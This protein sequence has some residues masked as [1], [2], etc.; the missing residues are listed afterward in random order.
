MN[1]LLIERKYKREKGKLRYLGLPSN[2]MNDV[3]LWIDY[4][5]NISAVERG[6]PTEEYNYQH[7]LMLTAM[8]H[9]IDDKVLIYRG[10]MDQIL[11]DGH[12]VFGN[13][14]QYPF[15]IVSL[16]YSGGII[17]KDEFGKA[18]RL[19][20]IQRMIWEQSEK[21]H[22]FLLFIST[23]LNYDD[24]G[25]IR[26]IIEEIDKHLLKLGT[27]AKKCISSY[28]NHKLEEARLKIYI[29]YLIGNLAG[30]WYQCK[31][32]KPIFY[33]GNKQTRMMN[34]STYLKRTKKFAAGQPSRQTL[35]DIL[36][37]SAF[38]CIDGKLHETNFGASEV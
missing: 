24:K 14:L 22:N 6:K 2:K 29:P 27:D 12:D 5:E 4:L 37:L 18:N 10:E 7:D 16:D 38:E 15:D 11:L 28:L 36:N 20:S 32:Y 25:E 1:L 30:Q 9:H 13:R 17:Y 19:D 8:I 23:N 3:L 26:S 31:H 33:R 34:F 35:R 21:D